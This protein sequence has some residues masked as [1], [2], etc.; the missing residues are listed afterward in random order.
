MTGSVDV[1]ASESHVVC[2]DHAGDVG[3][4]KHL[5]RMWRLCA[6]TTPQR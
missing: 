4:C 2:F 3:L 1:A 5:P 6:D